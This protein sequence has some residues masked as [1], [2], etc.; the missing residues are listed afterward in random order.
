MTLGFFV[1]LN[2]FELLVVGH[3]DYTFKLNRPLEAA[4]EAVA[5]TL[6]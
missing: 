3:V 5:S 4:A 2:A 1:E 6:K